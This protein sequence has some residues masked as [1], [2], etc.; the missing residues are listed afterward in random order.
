MV[1]GKVRVD[2][3]ESRFNGISNG[4]DIENGLNGVIRNKPGCVWDIV[5]NFRLKPLDAS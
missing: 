1:K 2:D 4:G 3:Q 5:E